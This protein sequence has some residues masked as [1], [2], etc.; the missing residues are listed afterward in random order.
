MYAYY[1]KSKK[2]GKEYE[3][4]LGTIFLIRFIP[5]ISFILY[6]ILVALIIAPIISII[7]LSWNIMIGIFL[8]A[9]LI[10]LILWISKHISVSQ[11]IFAALSII[12]YPTFI[13]IFKDELN[14]ILTDTEKISAVIECNKTMYTYISNVD[15]FNPRYTKVYV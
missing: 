11:V 1:L 4:K 9:Y 12:A 6:G 15:V 10:E 5:L 13:Q 8:I 2:T 7:G 14:L 3:I